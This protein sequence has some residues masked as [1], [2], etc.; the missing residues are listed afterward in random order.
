MSF[1]SPGM[2]LI[3]P[4]SVMV[5]L[6]LITGGGLLLM[7]APA[8]RSAGATQQYEINIETRIDGGEPKI[9]LSYICMGLAQLNHPP[10][11]ITGPRCPGQTFQRTGDSLTWTANCTAAKGEG[12]LTF[13]SDN[14]KFSGESTIAANGRSV[15]TTI[16]ATAV[17]SCSL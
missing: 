1:L 9:G 17:D 2:S 15:Q 6:C 12:K 14:S 13:A 11:K 4:K 10:E 7:A 5:S 3:S 16:D 8:V